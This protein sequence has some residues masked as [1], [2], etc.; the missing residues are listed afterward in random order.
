MMWTSLADCASAC[1]RSA[2][3]ALAA[4]TPE[5]LPARSQLAE[6]PRAEAGRTP[7]VAVDGRPAPRRLPAPAPEPAPPSVAARADPEPARARRVSFVPPAYPR[8][9]RRSREPRLRSRRLGRKCV[10]PLAP[11]P[12]HQHLAGASDRRNV[13][14]PVDVRRGRRR[15]TILRRHQSLQRR[16]VHQLEN[17]PRAERLGGHRLE[18]AFLLG[19]GRRAALKDDLG[20][21]TSIEVLQK[22]LE[23]THDS[24]NIVKIYCESNY[25]PLR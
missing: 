20:H 7:A 23:L 14:G 6:T 24:N 13:V 9:R 17:V 8:A 25:N 2:R 21:V 3:R 4:R 12:Q 11:H 22:L 19:G 10:V 18:F 16:V 1:P 15:C 5:R